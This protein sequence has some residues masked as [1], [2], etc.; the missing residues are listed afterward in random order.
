VFLLYTYCILGLRLFM[1]FNE[2]GLLIKRVKYVFAHCGLTPLF[3][4]LCSSFHIADGTL[5]LAKD[6]NCTSI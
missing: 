5:I 2:I 6:K 1:L 3:F 4:A